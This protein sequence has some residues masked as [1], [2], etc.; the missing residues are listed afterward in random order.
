ML[1]NFPQ[2]RLNTLTHEA[3]ELSVKDRHSQKLEIMGMMINNYQNNHDHD[4]N[5]ENEN[6]D[7]DDD[8]DALR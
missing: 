5:D 2:S 3:I 6:G 8:D 7:D 1:G 4:H